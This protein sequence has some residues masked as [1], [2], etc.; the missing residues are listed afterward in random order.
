[1]LCDSDQAAVLQERDPL[2]KGVISIYLR[3]RRGLCC[4]IDLSSDAR[5][6]TDRRVHLLQQLEL[7]TENRVIISFV[8]ELHVEPSAEVGERLDLVLWVWSDILRQIVTNIFH[9]S[10]ELVLRDHRLDFSDIQR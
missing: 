7:A 9:R 8:G 2:V 3:R 1:M 5:R 6:N 10:I 4:I